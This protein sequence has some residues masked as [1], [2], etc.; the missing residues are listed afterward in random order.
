MSTRYDITSD[1]RYVEPTDHCHPIWCDTCDLFDD[2]DWCPCCAN[3]V[4]SETK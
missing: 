2:D 1:P 4:G 3:F